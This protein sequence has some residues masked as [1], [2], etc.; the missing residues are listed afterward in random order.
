MKRIIV[1]LIA[2]FGIINVI[3]QSNFSII[4][5]DSVQMTKDQ[6]YDNTKRF[7]T[8]FWNSDDAIKTDDKET[9]LILVKGLIYETIQYNFE[10]KYIYSYN[11]RFLMKDKKYK[12]V[13]ENIECISANC[14]I[15]VNCTYID[16]CDGCEFPQNSETFLNRRTWTLLMRSIKNDLINIAEKYQLYLNNS[17]PSD[18]NW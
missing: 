17:S 3:A 18:K 13:I 15:N 10:H 4:K 16:F 5:S 7:I 14:E 11:A 8:E 1:A 9:G 2:I 12:I 6:I